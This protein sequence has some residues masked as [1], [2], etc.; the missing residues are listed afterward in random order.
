MVID[1]LFDTYIISKTS[2]NLTDFANDLRTCVPLLVSII[3]NECSRVKVNKKP[4]L[5]KAGAQKGIYHLDNINNYHSRLKKWIHRFNGVSTKYLQDS[6]V[7]FQ[8]L[9]NRKME[10]D[11]S[12]KKQI[13]I[14][15]SVHGTWGNRR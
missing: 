10:S 5:L 8:L 9:D 15:A 6:L 12:K 3:E 7:W 4:Q 11:L 13:L 14:L 1:P 2:P